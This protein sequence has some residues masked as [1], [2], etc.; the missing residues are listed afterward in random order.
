MHKKGTPLRPIRCI[1]SVT[2]SNTPSWLPWLVTPHTTLGPSRTLL[3]SYQSQTTTRGDHVVL[4]WHFFMCIPTTE[5]IETI[6]KQF[7]WDNNLP[8]RT[9]LTLTQICAML[10]HCLNTTLNTAR[11]STCRNMVMPLVHQYLYL[12]PI[13]TWKRLNTEPCH[14]S[15][16]S[17]QVTGSDILMTP[18]SRRKRIQSRLHTHAHTHTHGPQVVLF[19]PRG[20]Q[21]R[22]VFVKCRGFKHTQTHTWLHNDVHTHPA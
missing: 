22:F 3:K 15:Q 7:L 19:G 9:A 2:F 18:G 12:L 16:E 10:D 11:D 14:P 8:E 6:H 17:S 20:E 21:S 13:S 4:Q 5:A 1:N